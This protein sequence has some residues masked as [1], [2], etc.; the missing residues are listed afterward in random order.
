VSID[1]VFPKPA[2]RKVIYA[3][4]PDP[5]GREVARCLLKA[6]QGKVPPTEL[7]SNNRCRMLTSR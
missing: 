2:H 4:G 7:T 3:D 5:A 1:A 6:A